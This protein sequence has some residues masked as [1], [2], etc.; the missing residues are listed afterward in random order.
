MEDIVGKK[1][2]KFPNLRE[3]LISSKK[4][5]ASEILK[6]GRGYAFTK[7]YLEI[8]DNVKGAYVFYEN[9]KMVY[10][11]ISQNIANRIYQH[12]KGTTHFSATFAIKILKTDNSK[13]KD[14]PRKD[15]C[16]NVIQ[17]AQE[18]RISKMKF[19]F[20]EINEDNELYLFEV[21]LAMNENT[22]YNTFETH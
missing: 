6:L 20:I 7:R 10:V 1:I 8:S 19:S 3:E 13:L 15:F 22:K 4:Y 2:A 14:K 18:E 5:D 11:G 9:D 17:R 16:S 12:I 21:W